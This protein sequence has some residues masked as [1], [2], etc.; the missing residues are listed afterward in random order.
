MKNQIISLFAVSLL[1]CS[2]QEKPKDYIKQ[3]NPEDY[4]PDIS[5]GVT[6]KQSNESIKKI[7][8]ALN[9]NTLNKYLPEVWVTDK[10]GKR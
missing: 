9:A 1:F 2:C 3:I 7:D 5:L 8:S 6:V 4:Y 10:F